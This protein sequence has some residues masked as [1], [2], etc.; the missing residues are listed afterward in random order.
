MAW[1]SR[2]TICLHPSSD[3]NDIGWWHWPHNGFLRTD[4]RLQFLL[5][6]VATTAAFLKW[7][8]ASAALQCL[9]SDVNEILV[10]FHELV[11]TGNGG[12]DVLVST[13]FRVDPRP[14]DWKLTRINNL[15]VQAHP[16]SRMGIPPAILK[17]TRDP[18]VL[19]S[20]P[21]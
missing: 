5:V 14:P 1:S 18:S 12:V 3:D 10:W 2:D 15:E 4:P 13:S 21:S 16:I 19:P 8:Y 11:A 17:V 20:D 6:C 9:P 7:A